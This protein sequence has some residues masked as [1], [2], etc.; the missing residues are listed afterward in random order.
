MIMACMKFSSPKIVSMLCFLLIWCSGAYC[1]TYQ[2]VYNLD[3]SRVEDGKAIGWSNFRYKS[4]GSV[5][6]GTADV[7]GKKCLRL[8]YHNL[9]TTYIDFGTDNPIFLPERLQ[10]KL[11][12]SLS[13]MCDYM[14]WAVMY[15][16][17]SDPESG[18]VY[19]DSVKLQCGGGFVSTSV[20]L[21]APKARVLDVRIVGNGKEYEHFPDMSTRCMFIEKLEIA[22]GG[23]VLNNA[24]AVRIPEMGMKILNKSLPV[25][26]SGKDGFDGMNVLD[27]DVLGIGFGMF[28]DSSLPVAVAEILKRQIADGGCRAV[29]A[30]LSVVEGLYLN[31]YVSGD[32]RFTISMI[33]KFRND[34]V[35]LN[36]MKWIKDFNSVREDKVH[37]WGLNFP[38]GQQTSNRMYGDSLLNS[39]VLNSITFLQSV[40]MSA[41]SP[42]MDSLISILTD[43]MRAD[44]D[45]LYRDGAAYI[46]SNW[47]KFDD[48]MGRMDTRMV[49]YFLA[50][51]CN[52]PRNNFFDDW[53][54]Y[55]KDSLQYVF[56]RD[57]VRT[58]IP[59][60]SP[61]VFLGCLSTLH[62]S[63]AVNPWN[64]SLGCRLR[65]EYGKRY[66]CLGI[67]SDRPRKGEKE[68]VSPE[69]SLDALCRWAH[70]PNLYVDCR[71]LG[72]L[73]YVRSDSYFINSGEYFEG[74]HEFYDLICP[75]S[76]MDGMLVVK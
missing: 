57:V 33:D 49:Q 18:A 70:S 6:V 31:R 55:S 2:E 3:F 65:E 63:E 39:G 66:A 53:N 68:Y 7:D 72:G 50:K 34:T 12:V 48:V 30:E 67:I 35:F 38:V 9:T 62:H 45:V 59:E 20:S 73:V 74:V 21:D 44:Y 8:N 13:Y 43:E 17:A 26:L 40:G 23:H 5:S 75:K 54:P 42:E 4:G 46:A 11:E 47:D 56:F 52:E 28:E 1:Q 19:A 32:E 27:A 14:Q 76:F 22:C 15:V 51:A 64:R 71:K 60:S 24:E 29:V 37:I 41:E 16:Y 36:L 61:I 58:L 10:G 69:N 25:E